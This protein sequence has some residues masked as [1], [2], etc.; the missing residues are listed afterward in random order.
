MDPTTIPCW[1]NHAGTTDGWPHSPPGTPWPGKRTLPSLPWPMNPL[2]RF[3][4]GRTVHC[5]SIRLN[6]SP[7]GKDF[8]IYNTDTAFRMVAA[9][10]GVGVAA[11]SCAG[12][13]PEQ[14]CHRSFSDAVPEIPLLTIRAADNP[15]ESAAIFLT[16]LK[17][18][19][20]RRRRS[21]KR[22]QAD[23]SRLFPG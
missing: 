15:P 11:D 17:N 23:D 8:E 16:A 19:A 1:M 21:R 10:L 14:I 4:N 12:I 7:P 5:G 3:R 6:F 9:G 13:F 2:F 22:M 20:E 18:Q